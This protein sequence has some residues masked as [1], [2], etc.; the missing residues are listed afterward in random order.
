MAYPP[1]EYD[2]SG[3]VCLEIVRLSMF[4]T[5]QNGLQPVA[6]DIL[7]AYLEANTREEVYDIAGIDGNYPFSITT[8]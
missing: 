4:F 2:Y 6:C 3:L 5:M 7:N 8:K 1:V